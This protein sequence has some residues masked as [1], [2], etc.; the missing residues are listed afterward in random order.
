MS[1]VLY[2]H[3]ENP[4]LRLSDHSKISL[5][6]IAKFKQNI[7]KE[8]PYSFPEQFKWESISSTLFN[9]DL[10]RKEIKLKLEAFSDTPINETSDINS[11]VRNFKEILLHA[12]NMSLKKTKVKKSKTCDKRKWFN[13][14]FSKCG[15]HWII[16]VNY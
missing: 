6:L 10:Q 15:K 11:I 12:A 5:R 7:H 1:N 13:S 9:Q 3:D 4:I 14:D 16:K 8:Y 2:F